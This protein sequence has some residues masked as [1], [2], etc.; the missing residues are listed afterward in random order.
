MSKFQ[1][2]FDGI[3]ILAKRFEE[4]G[5]NLDDLADKALKAT[6]AHITPKVQ[7]AMQASRY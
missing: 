1:L 5:G 2:D 4:M 7:R 6:H 3:E